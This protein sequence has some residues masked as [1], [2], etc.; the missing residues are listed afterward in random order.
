MARQLLAINR[1]RRSP[2]AVATL[3]DT[4]ASRLFLDSA[5]ARVNQLV[6]QNLPLVG[7]LVRETLARVPAHVNRDDLTSAAM[8]ALVVAAKG[9]D[10]EL[11]VPFARYAAIRIRG[12][13]LDELRNMDWA[14]RSVRTRAREV[15]AIRGQ[16]TSALR[17]SPRPAEVASAMGISTS[18]L[19]T[20]DGDVVRA[21]V[22]SFQ[23]FAPE[24]GPAVVAERGNGPEA[25]LVL[26][27]QLGYLHEAI[28]LLPD[29]LRF[30][31]TAYFFEQRQMADIGA[32][33]GV[34]ESRV[35]QLRADALTM[36]RDG[37]NTQLEPT[38]KSTPRSKRA[39]AALHAYAEAMSASTV[40]NRLGRTNLLGEMQ[41][42]RLIP[43]TQTLNPGS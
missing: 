10:A 6:E 5:T 14:V 42:S 12:G 17:R 26:R 38:A 20:V 22:L 34:S 37:L 3:G 2:A 39:G 25:I 32:E 40:N 31:V 41:R 29:R 9:F 27:E 35:S 33:L 1:V 28:D 21:Q 36:L 4:M 15:D 18:D 16:L 11:G 13:L 19:S 43:L 7:H 24:S 23:G 30:V 8:M